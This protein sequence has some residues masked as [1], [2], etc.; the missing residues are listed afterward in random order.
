MTERFNGF[1]VTLEKDIR[2]DDAKAIMD[3][4][5][6]LRGVINVAG[7]ASDFSEHVAQRRIRHELI[8]KMLDMLTNP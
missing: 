3:A 1:F 2:E 5:S 7:N 6:Q 8:S 4:I